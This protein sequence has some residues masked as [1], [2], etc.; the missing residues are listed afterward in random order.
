M[1]EEVIRIEGVNGGRG[2]SSPSPS[3][4]GYNQQPNNPPTGGVNPSGGGRSSGLDDLLDKQRLTD[5][6]LKLIRQQGA[7]YTPG[8]AN[9]TQLRKQFDENT[10][11]EVTDAVKDKYA[12]QRLNITQ[13]ADDNKREVDE[14]A[15]QRK[16]AIMNR[17]DEEIDKVYTEAER[18]RQERID[19]AGESHRKDPAFLASLNN[20]IESWTQKR[21]KSIGDK[22]DKELQEVDDERKKRYDEIESD[23]ERELKETDK[24]EKD[25]LA[26]VLKELSNV[27]KDVKERAESESERSGGGY[28]SGL[29]DERQKLIQEREGA[30]TEEEAR[31]ASKRIADIDKKIKRASGEDD[32]EKTKPVFDRAIAGIKGIQQI[33]SGA[34]QGDMGSM[35]MGTGSAIAGFGGLSIGA[36]M[37]TMGIAAVA[38]GVAKAIQG[39]GERFTNMADLAA[40]KPQGT[41]ER[42]EELRFGE[43]VGYAQATIEAVE[44]GNYRGYNQSSLDMSHTDFAKRAAQTAAARGTTDNWYAETYRQIGIEKY[45]ALGQGTLEQGSKFDR[46]G[47]TVTDA[48][49]KLVTQLHGVGAEGANLDD[50]SRVKEKYDFQQAMMQGYMGRTDKPNFDL[51]NR[52]VSAMNAVTGITHDERDV[53]DYQAMQN[54]ILAPKNDRMKAMLQATVAEIMPEMK[55]TDGSYYTAQD[56]GRMDL[57]DRAIRNPENEGK[58]ITAMIEK[59]NQMYGGIDTQMGYFAFKYLFPNISPDRLDEY[60]KQLNG[61]DASVASQILSGNKEQ[62]ERQANKIGERNSESFALSASGLISDVNEYLKQISNGVTQLVD[63]INANLN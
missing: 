58:I 51:A 18:M 17:T 28:L 2:G 50:F 63:N 19:A 55:A 59:I 3:S 52:T 54:A 32:E 24:Q 40:L 61:G 47:Q 20:E 16:N 6:Y 9:A 8:S 5:E 34:E 48:I 62:W 35:I 7:V 13:G 46:Y 15:K 30:A 10:R 42:S 45:L 41:R 57:I 39:S 4:S 27:L 38:A 49:S 22:G 43:K 36:A 14:E 60:V 25:E 37:S 23:K 12:Q 21:I 44:E 33:Y 26:T 31:A 1:A 29:R 53:S 56:A 11:R